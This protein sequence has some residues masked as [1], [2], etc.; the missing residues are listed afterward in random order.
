MI[1]RRPV[2]R[3]ICALVLAFSATVALWAAAEPPTPLFLG[4]TT[5]LTTNAASQTDSS[6]SGSVVVWTDQRN[7]ND[8]IYFCIVT[9]CAGT[10]QQVTTGSNPQRLNDVSGTLIAYTD[11]NGA[12]RVVRVFDTATSTTTTILDPS[13]DQNPRLD[14]RFVVFERGPAS[15]VDVY[16]V[17]LVTGIETAVAT[18][19]GLELSPV[20]G[21]GRVVYERHATASSPGDIFLYDLTTGQVTEIEVGPV[22][23]RRPDIDG[24]IVTWYERS[25]LGDSDIAIHDL[26]TGV[27]T[28]L[29]LPGN[30]HSPHVSGDV[31]AFDDNASENVDIGLYHIPTGTFE[32]VTTAP[33]AEFLTNISGNRVVYTSNETGNLDIFVFEFELNLPEIGVAPLTH[34]FGDIA[35]GSSGT[36]V[37]TI[38]NVGPQPLT[39]TSITFDAGSS[40]AFDIMSGPALP[41]IVPADGTLDVSVRFSPGA[42][43]VDGATLQIASD[44]LDESLVHVALSGRGVAETPTPSEQIAELLAFFDAAVVSGTLQGD[45]PGNSA[46]GRLTALRNMIAGAGDLI[47]HGLVAQACAQLLEALRR[48]DGEPQPPDFVI[49]PARA[50]FAERIGAIRTSLGCF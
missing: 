19:A 7:G 43:G 23:A 3:P 33:T 46:A 15:A 20:V 41:A 39:V 10:E 38:S 24:D 48:A 17:D 45:G 4:T 14:G 47:T 40:P 37:V 29:S 12:S 25:A 30:Q 31:V 27:T 8:D 1:V 22:D 11:V 36:T 50:E 6:I 35:V 2:T 42:I 49:G 18:T 26:A 13:A 32:E 16:A 44:D 28:R 34:D 9:D 21:D 5:Q